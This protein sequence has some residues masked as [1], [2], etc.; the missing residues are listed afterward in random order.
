MHEAANRVSVWAWYPNMAK[1][2]DNF[3]NANTDVQVCW[4]NTGQGQPQYAKFQTAIS[5]KK[6]A[7]DVI[8][9]ESDQLVGFEI[10]DALVDLAPFGAAEVKGNFSEGAWKDVSQGAAVRKRTR[11]SPLEPA[12]ESPER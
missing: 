4:I 10:Q 9:L 1:V 7:P 5:A 12:A 6:G 2:V 3:N 11:R 8:M